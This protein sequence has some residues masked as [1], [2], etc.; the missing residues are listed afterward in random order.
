MQ[1]YFT[2]KLAWLVSPPNTNTDDGFWSPDLFPFVIN[3]AISELSIIAVDAKR[4]DA[5]M[6]FL[7]VWTERTPFFDTSYVWTKM[8]K[9]KKEIT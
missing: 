2:E 7:I 6:L 1:K 8:K 9:K 5:I 4:V 3:T